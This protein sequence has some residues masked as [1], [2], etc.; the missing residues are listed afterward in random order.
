MTTAVGITKFPCV[1][2]LLCAEISRSADPA[3][4]NPAEAPVDLNVTWG[5]EQAEQPAK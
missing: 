2:Q 3:S 1:S 5:S 4:Q